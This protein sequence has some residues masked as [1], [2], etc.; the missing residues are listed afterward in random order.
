VQ[1]K[2]GIKEGDNVSVMS[3]PVFFELKI[4]SLANQKGKW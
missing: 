2:E 4:K 1:K 3:E